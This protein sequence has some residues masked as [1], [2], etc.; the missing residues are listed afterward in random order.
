MFDSEKCHEEEAQER[1]RE[2]ERLRDEAQAE[3]GGLAHA[4]RTSSDPAVNNLKVKKGQ[5]TVTPTY[6]TKQMFG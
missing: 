2:R 5:L 3:A 4:Q 1:A 6:A